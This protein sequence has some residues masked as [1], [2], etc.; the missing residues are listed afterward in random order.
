MASKI[1]RTYTADENGYNALVTDIT[2]ATTWSDIDKSD[3]STTFHTSHGGRLIVIYTGTAINV[4]CLRAGDGL[5]VFNVNGL[6]QACFIKTAKV[7]A[8]FFYDGAASNF[9]TGTGAIG[10]GVAISEG[11]N[12]VTG[13]TY[14]DLMTVLTTD[15]AT[16][17]YITN[18]DDTFSASELGQHAVTTVTGADATIAIGACSYR[19]AC[20]SDDVLTCIATPLTTAQEC[21]VTVSG[22][23]YYQ[24]RYFLFADE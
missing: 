20:I 11:V 19:S 22:K 16:T 1:Y 5:N 6:I 17:N 14:T 12:T 21:A 13:E 7:A 24:A 18:V 2:A 10:G 15:R 3:T 23:K 8:M 4:M 9:L